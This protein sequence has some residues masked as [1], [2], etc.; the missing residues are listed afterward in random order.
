M[1]IAVAIAGYLEP[2]YK[3]TISM[4]GT[5]P[6]S[7]HLNDRRH[8]PVC[9]HDTSGAFQGASGL[10]SRPKL[11]QTIFIKYIYINYSKPTHILSKNQTKSH[12]LSLLEI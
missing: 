11:H 2:W 1:A 3:H 7:A 5:T 4:I 6:L 8:S 10:R 9:T 12:H